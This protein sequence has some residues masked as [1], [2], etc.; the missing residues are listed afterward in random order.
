MIY[1]CQGEFLAVLAQIRTLRRAKMEVR[2]Q[3]DGTLRV[4]YKSQRL[5]HEV[6]DQQSLPAT[7][8]LT[9]HLNNRLTK[10]ITS[11]PSVPILKVYCYW[12]VLSVS[13]SSNRMILRDV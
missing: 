1:G 6:V 13:T 4:E 3:S 12:A 5:W 11:Q 7:T 2:E 9:K 10:M 8:T